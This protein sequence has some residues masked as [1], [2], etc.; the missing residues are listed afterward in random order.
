[1]NII[2]LKLEGDG[3]WPDLLQNTVRVVD[4]QGPIDMVVLPEGMTSGKPS[5]A[6]RL[7]LPDGTVVIVQ[8]SLA[9]LQTAMGAIKGRYGDVS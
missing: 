1:M 6:L 8:T 9:I 3:A 2:N 5:V 4:Y 7:D